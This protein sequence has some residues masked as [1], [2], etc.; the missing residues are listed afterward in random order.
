MISTVSKRFSS[1]YHKLVAAELLS[2]FVLIYPLYSIMFSERSGI[3]AAGVGVL[4][5]TV[6]IVQ[7]LSEIP[8]GVIADRY[9]KK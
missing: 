5:A 6:Y 2:E 3:S 1:A 4:L 9:S 7:I 8:T